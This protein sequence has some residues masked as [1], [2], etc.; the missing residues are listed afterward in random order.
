MHS[1][2]TSGL[3]SRSPPIHEPKCTTLGRVTLVEVEPVNV[4]KRFDHFGIDPRQRFEQRKPEIA[5]AHAD[6][7]VHRGLGQAHFVSLPE[8]SDF[9]ADVVFAVLRLFRGEGKPVEPFDS[10]CAMR[11]RFSRTVCRATSV[12]CAVNTGVTAISPTAASAAS[13]ETP[14]FFQAS[15]VP[16]NEPGSGACSRSSFARAAPA[17]AMV[18]LRQVGQFEVCRERLRDLVGAGQVHGG[19]DLLCFE[20]EFGRRSLLRTAPGVFPM[21]DQQPPQLL[22]RFEQRRPGLLDHHLT[23]YGAERANIAPQRMVFRRFVGMRGKFGQARLLVVGFPQRFGFVWAMKS[24][25][26]TE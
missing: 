15:R 12:G 2:L 5:Q 7:I 18:G 21:F 10:C 13:A 23:E 1:G 3:P 17:L 19:D 4:A 9:G 6:F 26:T 14:S 8:R 22:D 20:H 24:G 25:C 16:R 11:R